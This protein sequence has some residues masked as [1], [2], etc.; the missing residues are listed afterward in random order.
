MQIKHSLQT[1]QGGVT[2][3]FRVRQ[4]TSELE[5]ELKLAK[6]NL[7][8]GWTCSVLWKLLGT[9]GE[10]WDTAMQVTTWLLCQFLRFSASLV[11]PPATK[12]L[13]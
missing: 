10:S 5:Q 2:L 9:A 3:H 11:P 4:L 13:L 7:G 12:N 6:S 8:L 1:T